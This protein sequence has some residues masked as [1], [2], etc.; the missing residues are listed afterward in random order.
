METLNELVGENNLKEVLN[1]KKKKGESTTAIATQRLREKQLNLIFNP[2]KYDEL[3][4]IKKAV[5]TA[6]NSK[7]EEQRRLYLDKI[8]E[9]DNE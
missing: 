7:K 2:L 3:K 6:L 1:T 5:D 8:S 9:L 4:R